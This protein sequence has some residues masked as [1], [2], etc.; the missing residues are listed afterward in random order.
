MEPKKSANEITK[1]WE[2]ESCPIHATDW[3][4]NV[5]RSLACRRRKGSFEKTKA[6]GNPRALR[7]EAG[8]WERGYW[9]NW[10]LNQKQLPIQTT[11]SLLHRALPAPAPAEPDCMPWAGWH[12][13]RVST[14]RNRCHTDNV[15]LYSGVCLPCY[16]GSQNTG[17]RPS[18]KISPPPVRSTTQPAPQP[19]QAWGQLFVP[20]F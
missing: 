10:R 7:R 18:G 11:L 15:V 16:W 13:A 14:G 5:L 4:A 2:M 9:E 19:T 20:T 6:H 3:N 1:S 12:V 17:Y 8:M